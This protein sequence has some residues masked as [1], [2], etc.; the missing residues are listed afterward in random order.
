MEGPSFST[1]RRIRNLPEV[2]VDVIGMTNMPEAKLAREAEIC[3][4]TLALATDYD[5]WHETRT[6]CRSTRSS[7]SFAATSRTRKRNRPGDRPPA[8]ASGAV[9]VRGGR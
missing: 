8:S 1:P 5:C 4:A 6:M 9:P 7:T 3:Y 2:G